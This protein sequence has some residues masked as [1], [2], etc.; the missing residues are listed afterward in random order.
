MALGLRLLW[1][2]ASSTEA[3]MVIFY[4]VVVVVPV[5]IGYTVFSYRVFWGKSTELKY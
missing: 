2:A 1:Q 5:I 4:G 3:L